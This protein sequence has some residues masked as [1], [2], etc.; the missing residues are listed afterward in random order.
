MAALPKP[1]RNTPGD[2]LGDL[3]DSL[4][5]SERESGNSNAEIPASLPLIVNNEET[6]LP[7]TETQATVETQPAIAE[8]PKPKR[9]YK[10]RGEQAQEPEPQEPQSLLKQPGEDFLEYQARIPANDWDYVYGNYVSKVMAGGKKKRI[11]DEAVRRPISMAE[12]REWASEHGPGTY[13]VQFTVKSKHLSSCS[14]YFTFDDEGKGVIGSATGFPKDPEGLAYSAKV[15]ADI[16]K[17]A[18]REGLAMV[19][20]E[21]VERNKQPDFA[22]MFGAMANVFANLIPKPAPPDNTMIQFLI[23]DA[24]RRADA[25]EK[26]AERREQRAKEESDRRERDAQ[27]RADEAKAEADRQRERDKEFFGLMLK[28]A[29]SKADSLNQMT[30]LLTSFM[31]VKETIDDTMGGGPKGPWDLVGQVADGIIQNGPA[32]VAAV[33]GA[34][35]QQVQQIQNPQPQPNPEAQPFYE[36]IMRLA[37]YFQR[38]PDMYNGP[39]LVDMIEAEYGAMYADFQKTPKETI[40]QAIAAF[41]PYGKA[42]AEHEQANLFMSKIIDAIKFPDTMEDLFPDEEPEEK[43]PIVL[44]GRARKLNGKAKGAA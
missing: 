29:E 25:A 16:T 3:P 36:L 2:A 44:H 24:Q 19:R 9:P 15:A 37:K 27:R 35:P 28:Q 38:D 4:Q 41:E 32:I 39:Y 1:E 12:L 22:G 14:E 18:A 43:E 13:F 6:P 8:E 10:K 30:G 42:I 31:K 7:E 23:Q 17:E 26:D 11:F 33:K 40:L 5:H 20:E 21:R 34:T